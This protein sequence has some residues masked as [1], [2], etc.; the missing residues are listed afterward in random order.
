MV[1]CRSKAVC[2]GG[3]GVIQAVEK[4][5]FVMYAD[6][7]KHI[8]R[9]SDED[10]GKL[11]KAVLAYV[12]GGGEVSL[13][14][15]SDMAFSF[16]K[17]RIERDCEKWEVTCKK[18]SEAGKKGNE[19]RWGKHRKTSQSD[20]SDSKVSQSVA[21]IADNDNDNDNDNDVLSLSNDNDNTQQD[22]TAL[23][24]AAPPAQEEKVIPWSEIDFELV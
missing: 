14:P 20:N 9:L 11:I 16:I 13:S 4:K 21:N 7:Q 5:S 22:G 2:L 24:R 18:R 1:T 17:E 6:Y 19:I 3:K 10:A 12:N 23:E 15:A 8:A